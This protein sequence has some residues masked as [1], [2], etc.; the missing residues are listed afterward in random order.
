MGHYFAMV[1]QPLDDTWRTLRLRRYSIEVEKSYT[2]CG[3][4]SYMYLI[5]RRI[6]DARCHR[7]RRFSWLSATGLNASVSID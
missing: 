6:P 4:S 2:R 7:N 3:I 1:S 5:A